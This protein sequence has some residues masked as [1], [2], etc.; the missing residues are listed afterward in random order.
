MKRDVLFDAV[1]LVEYAEHRHALRHRRYAALSRGR[2]RHVFAARHGRVLL[3]RA[4]FAGR[5]R[6]HEQQRCGEAC[7]AYSG[8]QGS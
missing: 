1:A 8:I 7:H 6:E 5:E 3:L 2:G 4:A